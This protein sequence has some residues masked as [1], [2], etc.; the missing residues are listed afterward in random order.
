[1][2]NLKKSQENSSPEITA[3][4]KEKLEK[5]KELDNILFKIDGKWSVCDMILFYQSTQNLYDLYSYNYIL[6]KEINNTPNEI[7]KKFKFALALI[8]SR[9]F[10]RETTII[11]ML[12]YTHTFH[13]RSEN[14]RIELVE[15]LRVIKEK[16]GSPG[17]KD[18]AGAGE[19]IGHIK[20]VLFKV[21]DIY[22]NKKK[23]KLETEKSELENERIKIANEKARIEVEMYKLDETI[24]AYEIYKT[25]GFSDKDITL[26]SDYERDNI[27][28]IL[29]L[30]KKEKIKEIE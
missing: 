1:L 25:L 26:I 10:N 17:F 16:Y 3:L 27:Y 23:R 29:Q 15:P 6:Q 20:E 30:V 2:E 14:E 18:I 28:R 22:V 7:S 5:E 9:I 4:D 11:S 21:I 24:K 8:F 13:K 12:N 19:I